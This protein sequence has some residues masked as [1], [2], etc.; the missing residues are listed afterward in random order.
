[1]HT[2]SASRKVSP[3]NRQFVESLL[4]E[5]RIASICLAE[6]TVR[7]SKASDEVREQ[8][9]RHERVLKQLGDLALGQAT[10]A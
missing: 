5:A 10:D 4:S 7:Q 8:K 3:P 2:K 1:M 6:A 9:A